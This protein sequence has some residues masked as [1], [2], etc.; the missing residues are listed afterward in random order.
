M[1]KQ[2]IITLLLVGVLAPLMTRAQTRPVSCHTFNTNLSINMS[3][4]E[5]TAMQTALTRAGFSISASGR[6]DEVMASAVS[7]FQL[8]YKSEILTANG[9]AYPTGY[10]GPA[11]RRKMNQLYGC[12]NAIVPPTFPPPIAPSPDVFVMQDDGTLIQSTG[13]ADPTAVAKKFYQLNPNKRNTY[14]FLSIFSTFHDTFTNDYHMTVHSNVNGIGPIPTLGEVGLPSR[15]LGINYLKDSYNFNNIKSEVDIKNNLYKI[16]HETG[17][18]WLAYLGRDEGISD[19]MHY[20][21][22]VNNGFQKNGEWWS[23]AMGGWPW[24]ENN[25]GTYRINVSVNLQNRGFSNLSLYLMGLIPASE[26]SDFQ[27]IIPSDPSEEGLIDIRASAKTIKISDII[28]KYG[29][30]M[31]SYQNSQKNFRMAY[32]L[33]TKKGE[34]NYQSNQNILNWISVDFPAEWSSVTYGKSTINQ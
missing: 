13:Q 19:G 17:H 31:P 20:S 27:I 21:K 16:V 29:E 24:E 7:S 3:G 18:Q 9:F 23:D 28:T 15:L 34:T 30:R 11:T 22:W 6:F 32:I 33:L 2:I 8:K 12:S 25:D 10:F 26:V 1:K 4:S 14:D 5:V